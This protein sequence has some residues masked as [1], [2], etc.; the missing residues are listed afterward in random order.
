MTKNVKNLLYFQLLNTDG[1]YILIDSS[2][3]H[4]ELYE[5]VQMVFHG[6][7]SFN[8]T[9]QFL[10]LILKQFKKQLNDVFNERLYVDETLISKNR[11]VMLGYLWNKYLKKV[12]RKDLTYY[13]IKDNQIWNGYRYILF[14]SSC[15][16]RPT[17]WLYN[18]QCGNVILEATPVYPWFFF[19]P[20]SNE[21]FIKYSEWMKNYK[22]ILVRIIS[23]ETVEQWLQQIDQLLTALSR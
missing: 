13:A 8:I 6:A 12:D 9:V 14:E 23:K 19:M 3:K 4:L 22:S 18:D 11:E 7:I 2:L 5:N 15:A 10:D 1:E 20:K 17:T 16:Y 21:N